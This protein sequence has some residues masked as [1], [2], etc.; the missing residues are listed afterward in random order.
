MTIRFVFSRALR[1]FP[2]RNVFVGSVRPCAYENDGQT[3]RT[4]AAAA[5]STVTRERLSPRLRSLLINRPPSH[6]DRPYPTPARSV[7]AASR[8]ARNATFARRLPRPRHPVREFPSRAPEIDEVPGRRSRVDS[9]RRLRSRFA[10]KKTST[11]P[12]VKK[13]TVSN[14]PS[15]GRRGIVVA[16]TRRRGGEFQQR[17]PADR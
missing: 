5:A 16:Q 12:R 3:R 4:A 17:S 14:D 6:R 7:S 9:A 1:S 15:L 2:A 11:G 8:A 13:T 10:V